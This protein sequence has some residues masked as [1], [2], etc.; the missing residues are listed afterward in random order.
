MAAIESTI[1]PEMAKTLSSELATIPSV[2]RLL[3][4]P[5]VVALVEKY[6]H[7]ATS[8]AVRG[9]LAD[10]RARLKSSNNAGSTE[11]GPHIFAKQISQ[12]LETAAAPSLK[13][14]FN[15]TGT[16]LHTNLG[17]APL[18]P[19][20][21]E[22]ITG[23]ALQ[24]SNLEFDIDS[25]RRGDRDNHLEA[26][27]CRLTGAE[28]ATVVNNNAAAVLLTL[29]SIAL[30]KEVA[31]S[32]GELIE[33]GGSFRMPDIMARAGC[34]LH[35]VGTTNRTHLYDFSNAIGPRMAL[36]M[37]VHTSNY[38]VKGF[39][40]GVAEHDLAGLAHEHG[41]PFAVDLGSGSLVDL[42]RWGLPHEPTPRE[43]LAAG[44]DVVTFSGDKL[45]GGPQAG[46][47]VG[48]KA[49]V[50]KIR[51]NPMKRA[52]RL[53][54][55]SIAALD[56]VLRLYDD[57]DRL[58]E[59][60]PALR[61]LVRSP[62]DITAA[63]E[64]LMP[65]MKAWV[66]ERGTVSLQSVQSQIGSGAQPAGTLTSAAIAIHPAGGKKG[67]GTRLR[68]L[69]ESLRALP[70]PVIGRVENNALVLDLRCLDDEAGFIVQIGVGSTSQ[71]T[72]QP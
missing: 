26:R 22:A 61:W 45:L 63:A 13:R 57:P 40:A 28:A 34:R 27:I 11:L 36:I 38:V 7:T 59:K 6:G 39:T 3:Q 72:S 41:L 10:A 19:E 2:N 70:I 32:R 62:A 35:E 66:G 16:V 20:V 56:A 65:S 58:P 25:G 50:S 23:A 8:D 9:V 21:V 24:P 14:V 12:R 4:D 54:K 30:R 42:S 55:L 18:P 43:T 69:N 49:L 37:K 15:L 33:I 51:R 17:R 60:L 71:E 48:T 44:A 5:D 53:G 46:I 68:K 1:D 47:I 67:Q 31:V 64:R 29:N 52:M